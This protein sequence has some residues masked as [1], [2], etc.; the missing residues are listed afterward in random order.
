M[1]IHELIRHGPRTAAHPRFPRALAMAAGLAAFAAWGLATRAAEYTAVDL[2]AVQLPAGVELSLGDHPN[3]FGGQVVGDY[4]SVM[5]QSP[6][7][8]LW[9]QDGSVADLTPNGFASAFMFGT[10]GVHQFGGGFPSASNFS[11]RPIVWSG[12]AASATVLDETGF[13]DLRVLGSGGGQFVGT[14]ENVQAGAFH[15]VM[16]NGL[17][18]KPIDLNPTNFNGTIALGAGGGR[19]VGTGSGVHAHA[20]LWS[21]SA[22]SA[23]DLHPTNIPDIVGSIAY[24]TDGRQQVGYGDRLFDSIR[25]WPVLDESLGGP[26]AAASTGC[27]QCLD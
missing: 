13:R 27:R 25:H 20:L 23:V 15:A 3:S 1:S 21:G 24:G 7:A 26:D 18:A 16:W 6:V 19:Q 12:S 17:A 4:L 22:D 9:S 11:A 5:S 8:L 10:D 2:Y 14:G